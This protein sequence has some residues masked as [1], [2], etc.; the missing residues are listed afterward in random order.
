[1]L[2]DECLVMLMKFKLYKNIYLVMYFLH[3]SFNILHDQFYRGCSCYH[4]GWSCYHWGAR[5]R[6]RRPISE[7]CAWWVGPMGKGWSPVPEKIGQIEVNTCQYNVFFTS[8]FDERGDLL[9]HIHVVR[10]P[11]SAFLTHTSTDPSRVLGLQMWQSKGWLFVQ[12]SCLHFDCY[13][14]SVSKLCHTFNQL[15]KWLLKILAPPAVKF[16]LFCFWVCVCEW[17]WLP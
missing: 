2:C 16:S 12:L 7:I 13:I 1:M 10:F 6:E 11:I 8:K 9:F 4:C 14:I 17:G 15:L 5:G 3:C